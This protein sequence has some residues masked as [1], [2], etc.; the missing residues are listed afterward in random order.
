MATALSAPSPTTTA[1]SNGLYASISARNAMLVTISMKMPTK[2]CVAMFETASRS[3]IREVRS[4]ERRCEK[5]RM[6]SRNSR[7]MKRSA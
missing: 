5:N 6:G 1:Q 7:V 4:P 2:C 3:W